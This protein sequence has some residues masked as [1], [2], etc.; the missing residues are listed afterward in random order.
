MHPR[1]KLECNKRGDDD[2]L[3]LSGNGVP[4]FPLE[5]QLLKDPLPLETLISHGKQ[6]I[7]YLKA[8]GKTFETKEKET[9]PRLARSE[10]SE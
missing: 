5:T 8:N 1:T 6:G 2:L 4:V 10:H 9:N 7:G 3:P